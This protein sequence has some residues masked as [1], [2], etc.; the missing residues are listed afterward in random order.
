VRRIAFLTLSDPK[1]FVIDDDLAIR[2]LAQRGWQVETVHWN[3]P[4]VDWRRYEL[5]VIRSTWDY[6][7]HAEQFL[8]VLEQIEHSGVRLE[9][10]SEIA[11]WNMQDLPARSFPARHRHRATFWRDRLAPGELRRSSRLRSERP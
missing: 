6:H 8:R 1:N 5:V 11:R 9:N 7:H 3:R 2:P 4:G 10:S